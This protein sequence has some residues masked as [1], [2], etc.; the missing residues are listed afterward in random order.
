ML[1]LSALC[2]GIPDPP[3]V[4]VSGVNDSTITL[5]IS[6][7][8]YIG[9]MPVKN[10]S[11]VYQENSVLSA[12]A[13]SDRV[14]TSISGLNSSTWYTISVRSWN[15]IGRSSAATISTKKSW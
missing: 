4:N 6:P 7:P 1:Q 13:S 3:Y 5:T 11:V 10:Y 9:Q 14:H 8:L 15:D 2:A 12:D